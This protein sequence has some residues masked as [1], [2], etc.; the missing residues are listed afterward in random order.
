MAPISYLETG[1]IYCDENLRRLSQFPSESID[2]IYLDPP[3]FTNRTYEVI[4]GDEAEVRSF[5]DRWEGGIQVYIDWMRERMIELQRILKPTGSLY[6]HCDPT[7]SH[8]LKVMTDEV[9]GSRD[10]FVNEIIWKRSSAHSDTK[11]G[12]KHYG[13][14]S[15]T[16]LFYAKSPK[17]AWNQLYTPY[18]Q[19]YVDRDY[20]RIEAGTGRR[21]RIDNIQ[22]PGGASKGNPH[23]EFLGVSR[24]WRYS[25]E[26]MEQ[27]YEEGRIIQTRP[28]AVPQYKRYL[29]E[30]PGVPLQ[31]LWMDVPVINNRS[32]EKLGY[33]TQKPEALLE[34]IIATSSNPGDIILDPFCG[35][36][37]T[38]AV[39]ERLQRNW[40]G[41]DI[42]PTAVGLMK[43][44]MEKLGAFNVR[45][46]GMPV[47]EEQLKA[48]KPFEFQNW[49]IQTL[50]GTHAPRKSGDMGIDGYSFMEHAP[51][52][53]KQSERVG[54]NVVDNFETAV[55][56]SG[57]DAGMIVAF[58][59]G[60]GAREEVA[61]A[62]SEG[63]R[64]ELVTVKR[65]LDD[66]SDLVT[67]DAAQLW[68]DML[69]PPRDKAARPSAEELIS[70]DLAV[71]V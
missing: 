60:R 66:P 11:Q 45:L 42:S 5:E 44:R 30:M 71:A 65:L 18:E 40:L 37:T 2:L 17:R 8:Y 58:S 28:G 54:R 4:W 25:R 46:V 19:E 49:V 63:L 53:V 67:P 69:P 13:R 20:R 23:Y 16:I 32:R 22:G 31:N 70:S 62:R 24:Y 47:T 1:V 10:R 33:P 52:Q 14:L 29:D 9:F 41:I 12:A 55:R 6:L 56:R 68:R 57:K 36:G 7:A 39:A 15:D 35:C 27:L 34:R 51:I 43:R 38:I 59:F 26:R 3:F 61:R 48:L 50:H 64:L 21:Y